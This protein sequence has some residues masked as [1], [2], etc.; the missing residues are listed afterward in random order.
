MC[1]VKRGEMERQGEDLPS[2]MLRRPDNE[3]PFF[4]S[5]SDNWL[6]FFKAFVKSTTFQ[7][8]SL[9]FSPSSPFFPSSSPSLGSRINPAVS[10]SSSRTI[11]RA[12]KFV[13][14]MPSSSSVRV[15]SSKLTT[16]ISSP[17]TPA[18]AKVKD[19]FPVPGGP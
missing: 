4:F 18:K 6:A 2:I 10:M 14:N 17:K 12:G 1:F 13:N 7:S 11:H 16:W 3:M 5:S 19:V 8:F 9:L 15:G